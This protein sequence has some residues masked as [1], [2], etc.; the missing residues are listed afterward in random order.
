MRLLSRL[1]QD[2]AGGSGTE[3]ELWWD[4]GVCELCSFNITNADTGVK[5]QWVGLEYVLDRCHQKLPAHTKETQ[6]LTLLPVYLLQGE[7]IG[8]VTTKYLKIKCSPQ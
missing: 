3:S 4:L 1:D 5:Q 7:A 2:D 6:L 8:F